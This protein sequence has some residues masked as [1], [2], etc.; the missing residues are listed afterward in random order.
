MSYICLRFGMISRTPGTFKI[1]K[2][3]ILITCMLYIFQKLAVAVLDRTLRIVKFGDDG[4]KLLRDVPP[5]KTMAAVMNYVALNY[6]EPPLLALQ[7][8]QY[9]GKIGAGVPH[10]IAIDTPLS[11]IR[12]NQRNR[13]VGDDRLS[14]L[15]KCDLTTAEI[16]ERFK[17][18]MVC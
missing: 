1:P 17:E 13:R 4:S 3:Q 6:F 9:S 16:T 7:P 10:P 15:G 14:I 11:E 5:F 2:W 8:Y 12:W 18:K